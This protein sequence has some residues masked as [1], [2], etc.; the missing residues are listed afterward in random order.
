M[1]CVGCPIAMN[2][3]GADCLSFILQKTVDLQKGPFRLLYLLLLK[4]N[5]LDGTRALGTWEKLEFQEKL[6]CRTRK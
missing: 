2:F 6:T 4:K 3:H 5:Q 1:M